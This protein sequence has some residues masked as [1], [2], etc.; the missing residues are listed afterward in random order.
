MVVL[1]LMLVLMLL[2]FLLLLLWLGVLVM[3]EVVEM[4]RSGGAP[5]PGSRLLEPSPG[6]QIHC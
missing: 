2:L 6:S 1:R 4:K 5:I 3:D